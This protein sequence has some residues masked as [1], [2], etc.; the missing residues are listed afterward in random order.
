[1]PAHRHSL[2]QL[3]GDVFLTDGGL[4]TSLIFDQG[5]DLPHFA[6][7]PLLDS[8]QGRRALQTYLEP[9]LAVA[10]AHG[11]GFVLETPTCRATSDRA[12][13]ATSSAAR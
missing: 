1:M 13:T 4:E 2:P 12:A 5:I 3:A 10:E 8:E 7:Y 9:Y 6:A 11:T